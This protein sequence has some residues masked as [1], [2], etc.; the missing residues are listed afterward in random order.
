MQAVHRL[1]IHVVTGLLVQEVHR[2][3]QDCFHPHFILVHLAAIFK[4]SL[5]PLRAQLSLPYM[6]VPT[7]VRDMRMVVCMCKTLNMGAHFWSRVVYTR[8]YHLQKW[9]FKT[10]QCPVF[11]SIVQSSD[12]SKDLWTNW[13]LTVK[14]NH[15]GLNHLK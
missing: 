12:I 9:I 1:I 14:T 7:H 3:S 11:N 5:V 8:L 15:G 6:Y 4:A 13:H 2:S 10:E